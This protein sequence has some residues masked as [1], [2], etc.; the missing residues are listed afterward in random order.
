MLIKTA[1]EVVKCHEG[2]F[3]T[4]FETLKCVSI[5]CWGKKQ[6]QKVYMSTS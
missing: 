2:D 1:S 6:R 5:T 3:I 4:Y